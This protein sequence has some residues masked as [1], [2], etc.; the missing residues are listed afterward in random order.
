MK[1]FLSLLLL[2][3]TAGCAAQ[4][5]KVQTV[6]ETKLVEPSISPDLLVCGDAPEVPANA[7]MQSDVAH[8]LVG[9]WLWG[10]EC[11]S[12]LLAVKQSLAVNINTPVTA[13]PAK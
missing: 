4:Q 9:L 2:L 12:H 3:A 10:N 1:N 8:Y 6:V 7:A 11:Q 13:P 5:P